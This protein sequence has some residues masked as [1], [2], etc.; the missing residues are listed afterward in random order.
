MK[1]SSDQKFRLRK[2]DAR[3][4]R[5][6]AGAVLTSRRGLSGVERRTRRL[7]SVESKRPMFEEETSA[8]SGMRVHDPAQ[9]PTPKNAPSFEPPTPRGRSASRKRSLTG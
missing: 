9:G 3:N 2:F 8:V 6:E 5:V 4:E 7:L 1:M